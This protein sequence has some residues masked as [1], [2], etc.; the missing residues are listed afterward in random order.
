MS[1]P[2]SKHQLCFNL[3]I[4][5]FSAGCSATPQTSSTKEAWDRANDPLNLGNQY[6]YRLN[7][8]PAAAKV[9]ITPWTDTYWPSSEGGLANRW[10]VGQNGFSYGFLNRQ[11]LGTLSPAQMA[12]LSPAEKFDILNGRYDYPL[13]SYERSRT[14]P[15]NPG[16]FGLCHGW[17]NAAINYYEPKS[18]LMQN[19]D[20]LVIPFGSSDVKSLLSFYQGQIASSPQRMLG[21][22]CDIDLNAHPQAAL[23]PNCRD[24]NAGAF[25]VVL[26]NQ[27][28]RFGR[29]FVA[30]VTRDEQVWNQP[31]H[32]F[33]STILGY[34]G[35]SSG[36]A[37][38]TVQEAV[39]ETSMAY[40][41]EINPK[42]QATTNTASHH[43]GV[44]TYR[45]TV[46]LNA[47]GQIIGGQWLTQDRPDF[48][49]IHEP[50][51]FTGYY[52]NLGP[53]YNAAVASPSIEFPR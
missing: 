45:Y 53:L 14:S 28:G 4:L 21:G 51:A 46:E 40:T 52:T 37:P 9:N 13:A 3:L 20:G 42:W 48:L 10:V 32:Q 8:L 23:D 24:V 34:Q 33:S 44:K 35:V 15:N 38:G 36:A 22:R 11:M 19:G 2:V 39:M 18:V 6:E 47:Y 30:D 26:A 17:A 25:H 7:V 41:V 29:A 5:L 49:W 31:V 50:A 16:W 12:S 43:D 1:R 27:I